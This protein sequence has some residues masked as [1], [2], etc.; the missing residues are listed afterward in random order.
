MLTIFYCQIV[1]N[2]N[3][4]NMPVIH[5]SAVIENGAEIADDVII[6]P[7]V[8]IG[9]NVKIGSGTIVE[10]HASVEGNTK[11]GSKNHIFPYANIGG[12][13]QDLKYK[14]A[15]VGLEI[16][17]ENIFR[18]YVTIHCGTDE[19]SQTIIGNRNAFLAYSHVAHDCRVG[20]RCIMSSLS[21]LAGY[22]EV[23]NCVNIAWNSGVHQFCKV[24]DYAMIAGASKVTM[25][26]L[27]FMIV[28]GMPAKTRAFNKVNLERNNF[29]QADIEAAKNVFRIVFHKNLSRTEIVLQLQNLQTENQKIYTPVL[30]FIQKS[31][32]GIC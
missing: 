17:N 30:D 2:A 11:I 9:A 3:C 13:T 24:G 15:N 27:P 7:F 21:A 16:G 25:D 5:Q 29:S 14:G 10:H 6:G 32:R 26:V 1:L 22:V 12:L 4:K 23:G 8:Y 18:E 31:T 20:D 19:S 28:E